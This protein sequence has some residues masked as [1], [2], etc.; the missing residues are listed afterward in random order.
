LSAVLRAEGDGAVR[1]VQRELHSEAS[2]FPIEVVTCELETGEA[3]KLLCKYSADREHG[4]HGH[5]GG[6]AH[7]AAV[8]RHV[9]QPCGLSVPRFRG[10]YTDAASGWTWLVID[11]VEGAETADSEEG[12]F[13]AAAWLGRFHA[14]HD[15]TSLRS[16]GVALRTYDEAYYLGWA[17]RTLDFA[18][19]FFE[20]LP[21]LA[22]FCERFAEV[23]SVLLERQ[24]TVIHGE[25][26]PLNILVQ[27]G[28]VYPVDWEAAAVGAGEIDL[29]SLTQSWQPAIARRCQRLYEEARWPDGAPAGFDRALDAAQIYWLFRWLGDKRSRTEKRLRR[30]IEKLRSAAERWNVI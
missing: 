10:T 16:S 7:E 3:L 15:G 8:Y 20:E 1:V 21:W 18:A 13:R 17:Q 23:A 12:M 11:Y 30:R 14:A 26:Y 29:A 4:S 5:R 6:V 2:T 22:T 28:V 9:L 27:G 24:P 19:P 25:F